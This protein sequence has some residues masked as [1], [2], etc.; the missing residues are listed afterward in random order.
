MKRLIYISIF[1]VAFTS[2]KKA[3]KETAYSSIYTQD[4]Y[5]S[6]AEAEAAITAVYGNL[7]VMYS[8]AAPLFAS[9]WAADQIFPRNVVG[10]NSITTYT[11]DPPYSVQTSFSRANESPLEIWKR[12]YQGIESANW[13]IQKVPGVNMDTERR[14]AIVGE[15]LFLRA[16]FHWMLAKNFGSIVVKTTATNSIDAAFVG[17]KPINEV[18]DQILTDLREAEKMLPDY[19]SSLVKGRVCKQSAQI[20]H[21]KAALYNERWDEALATAQ[22]VISSGKCTLVPSA[23]DLFTVAKKDLA[24]TEVMFAVEL[25]NTSNPIRQSQVHYFYAPLG[26]SDLNKGGAGGMYVFSKFYNSFFNQDKRK[27]LMQTSYINGSGATV[28]QANIDTRLATKDLVI[29]AKLKDPNSVGAYASNN[30]YLLRYADAYLI[31]AEAEARKSGATTA[32]YGYINAVRRRA[33]I[34]DLTAGLSQPAFIDSVLRERSWE[35]Y[36]EG[37]RWYDLTRTNTF[38]TVIPT[39]I[40]ADYP[41]RTPQPKHK[42]Y[43]IPQIEIIANPM[44]EQNPDWK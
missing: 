12:A 40:N 36:G 7:Y 1:L 6:A 5:S 3:L 43:P 42:Y 11:Y 4:F 9:D 39:A 14:N 16:F 25:N 10:R 18:Y 30:L 2:C 27:A 32:A 38:M 19:S 15:A 33:E 17:K 26:I 37:D 24:R 21:A 35:F 34:P 22:A 13:V 44:I 8:S 29:M 31:A 28:T 41:V 20:L 23:I